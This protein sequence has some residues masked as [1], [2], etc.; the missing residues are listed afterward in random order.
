QV[1]LAETLYGVGSGL[2][3]P[4][5][6]GL[7][8]TNLN[9]GKESFEWSIYSTSTGLGTAATAAIGAAIAN[10]IGFSTTFAFT[11]LL[12]LLGCGILFLLDRESSLARARPVADLPIRQEKSPPRP[13]SELSVN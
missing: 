3:Y 2:A 5:W 13:R 10:F 7:W 1:Y 4:T 12:C 6:V 8:S 11:S 9:Q